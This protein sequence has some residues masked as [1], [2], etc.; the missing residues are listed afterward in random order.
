[1]GVSVKTFT[2]YVSNAVNLTVD[3]AFAPY[4]WQRPDDLQKTA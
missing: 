1:M 2:N 4:R 3:D